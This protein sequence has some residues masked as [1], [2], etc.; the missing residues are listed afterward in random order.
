[1]SPSHTPAP[2]SFLKNKAKQRNNVY[3]P[4]DHLIE[5]LDINTLKIKMY[6][7]IQT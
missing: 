5:Y 7:P 1:M 4:Y 2:S 6:I 3:L